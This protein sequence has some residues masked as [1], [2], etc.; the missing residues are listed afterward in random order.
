MLSRK[1]ATTLAFLRLA[2]ATRV[3]PEFY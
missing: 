1:I 2:I 3:L